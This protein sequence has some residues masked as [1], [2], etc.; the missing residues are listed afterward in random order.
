M[1]AYLT[2]WL[3]DTAPNTTEAARLPQDVE[4]R[5]VRLAAAVEQLTAGVDSLEHRANETE[6]ELRTLLA[7]AIR[8]NT[9]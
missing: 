3:A 1:V 5:L 7:Q 9:P 8:W 4:A 6:R 2:A